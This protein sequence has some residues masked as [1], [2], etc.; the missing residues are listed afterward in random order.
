M[1][2][3]QALR[4]AL[5]WVP[6]VEQSG[7]FHRVV[8][9]EYLLDCLRKTRRLGLLG[10]IASLRVGGRFNPKGRFEVLYLACDWLTAELEAGATLRPSDARRVGRQGS[11]IVRGGVEGQVT[12]VLDL[13]NSEIQKALGTNETELTAPWQ[14]LQA[15]RREAPTQQLGRV[16]WQSRRIEGFLYF[17]GRNRPDG[18]CLAVFP[19]RLTPPSALVVSDDS[20][21]LAPERL[22]RPPRLQPARTRRRRTGEPG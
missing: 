18:R 1:H 14:M 22:P 20:G 2:D 5:A 8:K 17:S 6:L 16:A 4:E 11:P 15:L 7:A 10:A 3:E 13:T 21:R 19:D 9:L 12:R